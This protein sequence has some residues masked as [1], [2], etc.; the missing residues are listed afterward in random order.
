VL[1]RAGAPDG[2]WIEDKGSAVA[3]H[4]RRTPDP[5]GALELLR[6]PVA[7]LAARYDLALEPGRMVLELRPRGMDKGQALAAFVHERGARTVMFSGDDLGDLAAFAAVDAL[8]EEGLAGLK[9]CSGSAE[10]T[11]LARRAD[12]VVDGPAG[13]VA[14]FDALADALSRLD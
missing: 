8:R 11:E 14:L 4:T 3:V 9:V 2:T 7:E 6:G 12:I 10:V 5:D 13:V 1:A